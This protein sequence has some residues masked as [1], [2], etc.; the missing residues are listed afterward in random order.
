M[1]YDAGFNSRTSGAAVASMILGILGVPLVPCFIGIPL[2]VAALILGILGVQATSH[3][4]IR[5]RGMAVT[6][7]TF[8]ALGVVLTVV[9][10][11]VASVTG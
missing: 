10:I 9:S 1:V 11:A 7:I 6:G 4:L 3:P 8:G 5:G 2:V